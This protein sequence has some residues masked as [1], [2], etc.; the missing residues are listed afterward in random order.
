MV[1]EFEA[2]HPGVKINFYEV[3]F[4]DYVQT[5]L[6]RFAAGDAPD[7]IDLPAV[8]EPAFEPYLESLDSYFQSDGN[9]TS[10]WIKDESYLVQN[11]HH[12]GLLLQNT[13]FVLYYNK[14]ILAA[15]HLSVPTT[16]SELLSESKALTGNG[17]YGIGIPTAE[18]PNL[19][20]GSRQSSLVWA[21]L[22]RERQ[23][24]HHLKRG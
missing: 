19:F 11:G 23:V 1:K 3:G 16:L 9:L 14:S 20:N 8:D 2:N 12:Y 13:G 21:E 4:T 24:E 22:G 18:D 10:R 5:M 17:N 15:H 7:I 6:D